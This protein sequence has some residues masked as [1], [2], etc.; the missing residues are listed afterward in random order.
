MLDEPVAA[1]RRYSLIDRAR[2]RALP[3]TGSSR[4]WSAIASRRGPEGVGRGGGA[5]R[6]PRVPRE[7]RRGGDVALL[8]PMAAARARR[9]EPGRSA[10]RRA[11]GAR[12]APRPV[13]RL[14]AGARR[15]RGGER[16][17]WSGRSRSTR[18]CSATTI[19]GRGRAAQ[20]RQRP[21]DLGDLGARAHLER[22]LAID[23]ASF[24][25]DP[26]TSRRRERPRQRAHGSGRSAGRPQAPGAR[27]AI[28]EATYGPD[29]P[30]VAIRL[31]NLGALF[32][33]LG[34]FAG[35]RVHLERALAIDIRAYSPDH[36]TVAIGRYEPRS[37][38]PRSRRPQGSARAVRGGAQ[39]R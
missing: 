19:R 17:T 3:C 38:A 16:S 13:R 9:G 39:D 30:S 1:L 31:N 10:R 36:P 24:G 18:P 32:R 28:D 23:I 33:D 8:R 6:R 37:A 15:V 2:G 7:R 12:A 14:P 27:L 26:R 25:P 29:D 35:A 4:R 11:G 21:H 5:T 20:P 22:A 34:D